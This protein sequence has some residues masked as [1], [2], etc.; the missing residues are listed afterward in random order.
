MRITSRTK[1]YT[2]WCFCR[3]LLWTCTHSWRATETCNYTSCVISHPS[4]WRQCF[5]SYIYIYIYILYIIY[6]FSTCFL[7]SKP[8]L[9]LS[10]C[11]NI[12]EKQAEKST[13]SAFSLKNRESIPSYFENWRISLSIQWQKKNQLIFLVNQ[14]EIVKRYMNTAINSTPNADV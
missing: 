1:P 10:N 4:Q 8:K 14:T 9:Y 12:G 3:Q 7:S 6:W 11:K 5:F 13:H 2:V